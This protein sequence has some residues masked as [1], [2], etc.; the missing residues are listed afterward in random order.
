MHRILS[1]YFTDLSFNNI[2]VR[3]EIATVIDLECGMTTSGYLAPEA[4]Q[5]GFDY[6]TRADVFSFGMLLWSIENKNMPRPFM[7]TILKCTG[8]FA[9]VM[10]RCVDINP[11]SRPSM[12][13]A[14]TDIEAVLRG[15]GE[16]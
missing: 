9:D 12:G 4:T 16:L 1:P 13:R 14:V 5:E 15:L 8:P 2:V 7:S 11:A 3:G 10:R 6:D